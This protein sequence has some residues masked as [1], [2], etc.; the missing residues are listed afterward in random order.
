MELLLYLDRTEKW[1]NKRSSAYG[2]PNISFSLSTPGRKICS[3][4]CFPGQIKRWQ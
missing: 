1:D 3:A 4:R 2:R